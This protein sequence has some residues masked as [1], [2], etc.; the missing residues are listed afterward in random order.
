MAGRRANQI[1]YIVNGQ[2]PF[3]KT[4]DTRD[5][6]WQRGID[7]RPK[8]KKRCTQHNNQPQNCKSPLLTNAVGLEATMSG[9]QDKNN[10]GPTTLD[11]WKRACYKQ[12]MRGNKYKA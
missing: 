9:N 8:E 12:E 1:K 4:D 3:Q 5:R 10:A 2:V 11:E 6:W 7:Q